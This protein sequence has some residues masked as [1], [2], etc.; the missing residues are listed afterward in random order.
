MLFQYW[1]KKY[2]YNNIAKKDPI[3]QNMKDSFIIFPDRGCF[4]FHE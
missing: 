3:L 1:Y 2:L 4:F